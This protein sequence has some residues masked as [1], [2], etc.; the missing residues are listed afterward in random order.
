MGKEKGPGSETYATPG[1]PVNF[2][3]RNEWNGLFL[4][5]DIQMFGFGHLI[6]SEEGRD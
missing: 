1:V 3:W 4:A 5:F 6:Y 2:I